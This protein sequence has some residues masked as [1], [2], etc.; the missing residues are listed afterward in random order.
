MKYDKQINEYE[1]T[2]E[3]NHSIN[4]WLLNK[5]NKKI[6][7]LGTTGCLRVRS[8]RGRSLLFEKRVIILLSFCEIN[9]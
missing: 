4:I 6:E 3:E 9:R 7:D 2:I 8:T 1:I 5:K